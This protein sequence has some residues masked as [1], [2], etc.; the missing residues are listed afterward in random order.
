MISDRI[1]K[2]RDRK[3]IPWQ[4]RVIPE[5]NTG[6][7]LWDGPTVDGKYAQIKRKGSRIFVHR[8]V[9]EEAR[10]PIPDG[11]LVCHRCD[12][13]ACCNVDHLFLGTHKD[14]TQDMLAKGRGGRPTNGFERLTHCI[15][16]HEFSFRNT[17]LRRDGSRA[18]RECARL[19][20]AAYRARDSST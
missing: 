12:V 16:G 3:S 20:T 6:C 10:G 4:D 7:L 11:L 9:W 15:R 19:K 13:P 14:N 18:C 2:R 8:F 1:M 5:P 17:R